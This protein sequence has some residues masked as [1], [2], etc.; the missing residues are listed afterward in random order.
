[1]INL[2]KLTSCICIVVVFFIAI[3]D[4]IV[5]FSTH[6]IEDSV[7]MWFASYSGYCVPVFGCS[8]LLGHFFG[9][10][11]NKL[12]KI[13]ANMK[14]YKL[15]I[16]TLIIIATLHDVL[17]ARIL[18]ESHLISMLP[19]IKELNGYNMCLM[20][21]GVIAGKYLGTMDPA[22]PAGVSK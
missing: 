10:A 1:M 5:V 20:I 4:G 15:I 6:S 11:A 14:F 16:T 19:Y 9:V 2:L 17:V 3:Y 22:V 18:D 8:F 21:G 13:P 7:S 12:A